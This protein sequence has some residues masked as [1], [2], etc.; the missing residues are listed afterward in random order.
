ML[1]TVFDVLRRVHADFFARRAAARE[2][3]LR[4]EARDARRFAAD[5]DDEDEDDEDG[6]EPARGAKLARRRRS[7]S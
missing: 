5:D 6:E 3:R 2:L 7:T 1:A 4:T